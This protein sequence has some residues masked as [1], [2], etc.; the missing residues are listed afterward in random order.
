MKK[1]LLVLAA[2]LLVFG[3]AGQAKADFGD[4]FNV[5]AGDLLR[6]VID[7]SSTGTYEYAS[8]LGSITSALSGTVNSN[9][10]TPFASGTLFSGTNSSST[11]YVAYVA[12]NSANT[13]LYASGPQGTTETGLSSKFSTITSTISG[14][15]GIYNNQT[16]G[17]G[18]T[19]Y[20]SAVGSGAFYGKANQDSYYFTLDK[21][22]TA[23]GSVGQ[24][25]SAFN[26]EALLT[27]GSNTLQQLYGF[28]SSNLINVASLLGITTSFTGGVISTSVS[29]EVSSTPI[30][31]SV[32]LFGSGLLGLVGIRR[33]N[34][35]NF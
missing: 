24:F 21:N 10:I 2:C 7:E 20:A 3:V 12:T 11:L 28:T 15:T 22:G 16:A 9:S 35:F 29:S 27:N 8:D 26:A 13:E 33:K 1:L 14:L 4:T 5:P 34:I 23:I 18:N 32:L 17:D 30:P 31:P 25:Y 19:T 6:I